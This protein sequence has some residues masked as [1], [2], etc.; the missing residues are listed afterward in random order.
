M[1]WVKVVV[2]FL[3]VDEVVVCVY[4]FIYT[5][6]RFPVFMTWYSILAYT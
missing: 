5:L 3:V 4:L 1:R 6:C 2:V